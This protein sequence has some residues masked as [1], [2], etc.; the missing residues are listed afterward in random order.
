MKKKLIAVFLLAICV[1]SSLSV[2]AFAAGAMVER[3]TYGNFKSA[4]TWFQMPDSMY[5]TSGNHPTVFWTIDTETPTKEYY[6]ID[7]G[8][9]F[10][11]NKFRFQYYAGSNTG[12]VAKENKTFYTNS[13]EF[14]Q[15]YCTV[16]DVIS[17]CG[18]TT[19]GQSPSVLRY[20]PSQKIRL[21]VNFVD[22]DIAG[23]ALQLDV[24]DENNTLLA[25]AVL[26]VMDGFKNSA[27]GFRFN[28]QFNMVTNETNPDV[29]TRNGSYV[30]NAKFLD[31]TLITQSGSWEPM[32][33][34][35]SFTRVRFEGYENYPTNGK[36]IHWSQNNGN[37]VWD[38]IGYDFR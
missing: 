5:L 34:N 23:S 12:R 33:S 13:R 22:S 7:F 3:S 2:A 38:N 37:N 21:D 36:I 9:Q 6:N 25:Q 29:Y 8:L 16:G 10:F 26:P 20:T 30:F 14:G 18:S 27:S 17:G 32:T 1:F 35:N 4:Q 15:K 28:R 11:D 24:Y 31:G 19:S